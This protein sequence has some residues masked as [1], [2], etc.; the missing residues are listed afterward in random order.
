MHTTLTFSMFCDAFRDADRN[1]NFS[2][3]G[4]RALF[5]YMEQYEE[6]CGTRVE[7]DII[8]LCCEFTEMTW[9]EVADYYDVDLSGCEDHC[10]KVDAVREYL[11]YNTM[12]C[13]AFENEGEATFVF[14]GF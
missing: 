2:Y 3:K 14:Q 12:V 11:E 10:E 13:G 4:K 6:E 8:A 1:E 9:E 7:L 5:D